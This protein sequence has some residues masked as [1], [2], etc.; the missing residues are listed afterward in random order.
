MFWIYKL[1]SP[2][3]D[4][5][6]NE[7]IYSIAFKSVFQIRQNR[8][9]IHPLVP[10]DAVHINRSHTITSTPKYEILRHRKGR[11]LSLRCSL[12][13]SP[14]RSRMG[15]GMGQRKSTPRE[16]FPKMQKQPRN[17]KIS[18]LFGTP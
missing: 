2:I 10:W 11:F 15:H 6:E 14:P 5:N 4:E 17:P 16:K 8:K 1:L 12:P 18:G 9:I 3:D 13:L 7:N